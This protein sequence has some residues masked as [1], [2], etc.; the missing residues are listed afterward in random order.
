MTD[1]PDVVSEAKTLVA[2]ALPESTS[3]MFP[4]RLVD[5]LCSEIERLR[6]GLASRDQDMTQYVQ[7]GMQEYGELTAEVERLKEELK[8]SRAE[9]RELRAEVKPKATETKQ[10]KPKATPT[11]KAK[12][13][14]KQVSDSKKK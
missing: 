5:A 1:R 2:S 3:V 11:G 9:A 8:K 6:A 14:Q 13:S 10:S 4:V 12:R 7:T